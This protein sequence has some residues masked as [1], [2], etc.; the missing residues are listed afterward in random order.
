MNKEP[1]RQRL[2]NRIAAQKRHLKKV[3]VVHDDTTAIGYATVA[4]Y[5]KAVKEEIKFLTYLLDQ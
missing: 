3:A 2:K 1:L 5:K 4:G